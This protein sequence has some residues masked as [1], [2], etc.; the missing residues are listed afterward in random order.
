MRARADDEAVSEELLAAAAVHLLHGLLEQVPA[1]EV[2]AEDALRDL[3]LWPV[4]RGARVGAR[5]AAEEIETN[6]KPVVDG[7]VLGEVLV[8][9]CTRREA[10][11]RAR[12]Q[13]RR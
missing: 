2:L 5:G 10:L 3:R 6:V 4:G 8:A 7:L 12:G 13:G 9:D 1:R 11:L